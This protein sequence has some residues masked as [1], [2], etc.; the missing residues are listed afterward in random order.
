[1]AIDKKIIDQLLSD[2]KKPE[3]IIAGKRSA[4]R[5]NQSH[6]GASARGRDDRSSGL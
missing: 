6:S 5:D 1:M 4:Q 3:D 2:Y